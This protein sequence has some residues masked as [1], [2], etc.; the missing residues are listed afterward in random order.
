[1]SDDEKEVAAEGEKSVQL[2][3][4]PEPALAVKVKE[5]TNAEAASGGGGVAAEGETPVQPPTP[6][7]PAPSPAAGEAQEEIKAEA[8]SRDNAEGE[9]PT[10]RPTSSNKPDHLL[11]SGRVKKKNIA[12]IASGDTIEDAFAREKAV[13]PPTTSGPER[14]LT[15]KEDRKKKWEHI[16]HRIFAVMHFMVELGL[17]TVTILLYYATRDLANFTLELSKVTSGLASVTSKEVQANKGHASSLGKRAQEVNSNLAS[18]GK[19]VEGLNSI[20][21]GAHPPRWTIGDDF[22]YCKV[23]KRDGKLTLHDADICTYLEVP[24]KSQ[25]KMDSKT[26]FQIEFNR[27]GIFWECPS[28][29]SDDKVIANLMSCFEKYHQERR[30]NIEF[31]VKRD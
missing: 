19:K 2:P 28:T 12:E 24:I 22:G 5:E 23:S 9:R 14:S 21:P 26:Q 16:S 13:P 29:A 3:A 10:K 4:S 31:T 30:G 27:D 11:A 25:G 20:F 17:L 8:A 1:M 6:S 18:L 7:E 15:L